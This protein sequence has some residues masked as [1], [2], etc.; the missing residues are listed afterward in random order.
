MTRGSGRGGY[1]RNQ[2]ESSNMEDQEN[3]FRREG[4]PQMGRG[5]ASDHY[6]S[7]YRPSRGGYGNRNGP[8]RRGGGR[9]QDFGG[10]H[11]SSGGRGTRSFGNSDNSFQRDIGRGQNPR[12]GRGFQ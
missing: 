10:S 1:N 3:S 9:G 12:G 2:N 4:P 7:D 8:N 6:D 5:M 11:I